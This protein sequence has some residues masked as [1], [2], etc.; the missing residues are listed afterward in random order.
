MPQVA[1]PALGR[2][3]LALAPPTFERRL[4]LLKHRSQRVEHRG[5]LLVVDLG[6]AADELGRS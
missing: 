6:L 5:R 1:L 2:E 4:E 3:C